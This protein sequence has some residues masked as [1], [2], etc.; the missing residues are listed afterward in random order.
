LIKI[1]VTHLKSAKHV[2]LAYHHS[3]RPTARTLAAA[4]EGYG[5][6]VWWDHDLL[7]GEQFR[8]VITEVIRT[9]RAALVIWS[10]ESIN[11]SWV[12]D[13]AAR[14]KDEKKL[15][16]LSI[17]KSQ[18]P[19]GF[20]S[21]HTHNLEAWDGSPN[22]A[23]LEPILKSLEHLVRRPR[24]KYSPRMVTDRIDFGFK[25]II[26]T[27]PA[28]RKKS[29]GFSRWADNF[30]WQLLNI[31]GLFVLIS[32]L[33]FIIPPQPDYH[34]LWIQLVKLIHIYTGMIILVGGVFMFL[35][36]RLAAQARTRQERWACAEAA[37]TLVLF[38]WLPSALAQPFIGL[39]MLYVKNNSLQFDFPRWISLSFVL[40]FGALLLWVTGF[41]SAWEAAHFDANF[42]DRRTLHALQFKRNLLLCVALACTV[43][44]YG[45]MVYH[46]EFQKLFITNP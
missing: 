20:G 29:T 33:A 21:I 13:E 44:V 4:L 32:A 12:L 5:F 24:G 3:D 10:E 46:D 9:S 23:V 18:I 35:L 28:D 31:V 30:L 34:N 19:F 26:S 41:R 11:S 43:V 45:L 42:G 36:F 17:D 15:V 39:A 27:S 25:P 38:V 2:F 7:P 16:P 37:R 22:A 8:D 14:A 6:S 40:Y 1:L